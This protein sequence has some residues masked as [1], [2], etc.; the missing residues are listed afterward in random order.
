M[1]LVEYV[2]ILKNQKKNCCSCFYDVNEALNFSKKLAN[3]SNIKSIEL[4]SID[5]TK[6]KIL[7]KNEKI[8][9]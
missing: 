6:L 7:Y 9:Y 5:F 8:F 1:Y 3:C 2:K 4:S